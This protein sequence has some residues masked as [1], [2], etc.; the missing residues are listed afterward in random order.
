MSA[1]Y[2]PEWYND[3]ASF[4]EATVINVTEGGTN[5][6][7]LAQ[8]A[9]VANSMTVTSPNGGETWI[10]GQSHD[11]TWTTTGAITNVKIE[12]STDNGATWTTLTAS[13]TNDG[14]HT[15]LI[16][17]TSS[18]HCRVRVSDASNAAVF[19]VSDGA[20][21][22]LQRRNGTELRSGHGSHSGSRAD[23]ESYL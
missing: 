22:Y 15:W 7:I 6:G 17:Y 4:A 16:P 20:V 9:A 18:T 11:I 19:D 2:S 8:L 21:Q 10:W 5:S 1:G 23:G 14:S 12:Y 3:K 13:T